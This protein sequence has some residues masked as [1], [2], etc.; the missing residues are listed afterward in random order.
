MLEQK[1]LNLFVPLPK[2]AKDVPAEEYELLTPYL[3]QGYRVVH[4]AAAAAVMG[5]TAKPGLQVL[6]VLEREKEVVKKT[7]AFGY[8]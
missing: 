6:V 7:E 2:T 3:Q 5:A 4:L 8:A 1:I